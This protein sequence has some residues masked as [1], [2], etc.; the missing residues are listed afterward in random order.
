M[1]IVKFLLLILGF[2]MLIKGADWFVDGA[3][4]LAKKLKTL[5]NKN[6]HVNRSIFHMDIQF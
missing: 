4:G 2:V 5:T 6:I 1:I 3:A